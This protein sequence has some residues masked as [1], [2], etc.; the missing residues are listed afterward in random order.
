MRRN[1]EVRRMTKVEAQHSRWTFYEV[2]KIITA[3]HNEA[4]VIAEACL[5]CSVFTKKVIYTHK[6]LKRSF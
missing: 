5:F 2:V 3:I 4:Q 1:L 6:I